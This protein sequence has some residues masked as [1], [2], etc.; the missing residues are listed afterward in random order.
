MHVL[1]LLDQLA[2]VLSLAYVLEYVR[3][4]AQVLHFHVETTTVGSAHNQLL[5][6]PEEHIKS[7]TPKVQNLTE[8][9]HNLRPTEMTLWIE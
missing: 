8:S 6:Y 2:E 1:Q 3:L 9:R 7:A 4:Q 5:D